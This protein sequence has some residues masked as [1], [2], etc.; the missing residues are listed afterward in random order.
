MNTLSSFISRGVALAVAA[1]VLPAIAQTPGGP[2]PGQPPAPMVIGGPL[3]V[4]P[5]NPAAAMVD[6]AATNGVDGPEAI[7]GSMLAEPDDASQ[8]N[9]VDGNISD[10]NTT[11]PDGIQRPGRVTSRSEVDGRQSRKRRFDRPDAQR[12]PLGDIASAAGGTNAPGKFDYASFAVIV[13][14]NIFNPNRRPY[15]EAPP[16]RDVPITRNGDYVSLVGVMSY[17]EGDFAFFT[18]NQSRYET[19]AKL[20]DVVAGHRVTA[21]N[22]SSNSVKLES[23]TNHIEMQVGMTMRR[24]DEGGWHVSRS[25]AIFASYNATP[26]P[27]SE[28]SGQPSTGGAA[29]SADDNEVIKRLMQRREQQ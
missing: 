8:T 12:R 16:V 11:G 10:S 19:S 6:L 21:I 17:E 15:R 9:G 3:V 27:G 2:P 24:D 22:I 20:A 18:G 7:I 26:N 29:A 5:T 23:G 13:Q 28:A 25:P 1:V 14:R 4:V